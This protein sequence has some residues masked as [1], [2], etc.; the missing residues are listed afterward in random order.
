MVDINKTITKPMNDLDIK[1][2]L[3]DK[4]IYT[5]SDLAN[6]REI[7]DILPKPKDCFILLIESSENSGHWVAVLRYNNTIE[8]FDSYGKPPSEPLEWVSPQ[9]NAQLGQNHPYLNYLFN[10]TPLKVIY[11]DKNYQKN[12]PT[13]NSCGAHCVF[14]CLQLLENNMSLSKYNKLLQRAKKES[15]LT[16]D[17]IVSAF[18]NLR[19]TI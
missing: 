14:R 3:P 4:Q 10:K 6:V 18:I 19:D 7:E 11:N 1:H 8:Y 9:K 5:Y 16:Y 2:Y 17:Q 12:G 13:V 15:G